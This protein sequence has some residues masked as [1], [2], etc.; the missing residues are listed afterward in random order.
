MK[1][2]GQPHPMHIHNI[3]WRIL[4]VNGVPPATG[5][6]GWKDTFLVPARG[7]VSVLGTFIDN[8]GQYVSHCHNLEHEDHAMMFNFEVV[9]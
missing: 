6:D 3:Q 9:R 2:I 5:D 8:V 1:P 4:E 7:S